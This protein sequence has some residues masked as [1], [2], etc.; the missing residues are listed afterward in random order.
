MGEFLDQLEHEL[1]RL[2][3]VHAGAMSIRAPYVGLDYFG[4]EDA[5][6]F[7]GRDAERKR[8]IG[9]LRASRLTLLYAESGVGKSSLLRAGVSARLRQLAARSA[10]E[11]GSARYV[12]VVFNAWQGDAKA[13]LIAT[14]EAAV[15]PLARD[16]AQL[17]LRRDALE[18]AIEDV[19]AAVDATPLIILD[20]FEEHFLYEA[21]DDGFDD[22]LARCINRPDLRAHFLISVRED[23]YSQIGPRFKARIAN[24][25]GNYL[26]LD[27]LD[28]R[29]ARDAVV[30][31]MNAFNRRLAGR[32][33]ALRG[34]AR[35]RRRRARAG[36]PRARHHRRRRR[37]GCRRHRSAHA[38]RPPTCSSS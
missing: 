28:E 35:A 32:R 24:V 33:A 29:A 17:E 15:R 20:Q 26:H 37:A 16:D 2:A 38:W 18:D 6:L 34:R 36:P 27:F 12:P 11:R 14:L 30:E 21:D 10:A 13:D 25:Y 4:E 7:F 8:I 19:V 5:G 9:N 23:A 1:G 31:P 22:E 3:P